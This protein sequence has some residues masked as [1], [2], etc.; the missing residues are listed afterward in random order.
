MK[1]SSARRSVLFVIAGLLVASG[2]LRLGGEAGQ[3]I[4]S[5]AADET[6]AEVTGLAGC[7]P[8]EEIS[9][10]LSALDSREARIE[11]RELQFAN[12]MQALRVAEMEIEARLAELQAAES[13]LAETIAQVDTAAESDLERLVAVYE[14]MKPGDAAALFET[15]APEFAAGF[16]GRMR[17][18]AAAAIMAG[19]EPNTAY[20]ISVILAGRNAN[21]PRN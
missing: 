17:P 18:D 4:A 21:A 13:S 11:E 6:G 10:M 3:A 5:S 8:R 2:L 1:R 15:M 20:S 19:L 16:V 7:I 12:R 9:A 14:N